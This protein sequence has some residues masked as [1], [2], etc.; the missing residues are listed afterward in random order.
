MTTLIYVGLV[1]LIL[2]LLILII[3]VVTVILFNYFPHAK[4]TIWIVKH[5]ITNQDLDPPS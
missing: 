2:I 4:I 3:S 1:L 5:I